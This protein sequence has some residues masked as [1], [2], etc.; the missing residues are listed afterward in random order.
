MYIFSEVLHKLFGITTL[1][2][3]IIYRNTFNWH[4]TQPI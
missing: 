3:D 1:N 2:F 4:Y